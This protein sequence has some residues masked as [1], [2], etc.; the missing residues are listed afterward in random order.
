M[1]TSLRGR[2]ALVASALLLVFLAMS[3][4]AQ[5]LVRS[6]RADSD[7]L[8]SQY[9]GIHKH[10]ED[11]KDGLRR[12]ESSLYPFVMHGA[13]EG[14]QT[15]RQDLRALV[16]LRELLRSDALINGPDLRELAAALDHSLV[17]LDREVKTLLA[18]D[19]GPDWRE[20]RVRGQIG[21][22]VRSAYKFVHLVERRIYDAV[23]TSTF[24]SLGTSDIVSR[25]SRAGALM[26]AVLLL[27]GYAAFELS[28]RRPLLKVAQA[29]DAEGRGESLPP[30][31]PEARTRE[32]ALLTAAFNGMRRQVR[33]RQLRLESVLNNTSDG[34]I[35]IDSRRRIQAFNA[36]AAA[37]FGYQEGDVTGEDLWQ[38]LSGDTAQLIHDDGINDTALQREIYLLG[39]R[40]D[41]TV[42]DLSCKVSEFTIDGRR[43]FNAMVADVS[44]RKAMF[45]RLTYLAEHD[46]LT[47]LY[48]RRYF[49]EELHRVTER[50]KR[51]SGSPAALLVVDLDHFKLVNDTLGHQA[52]DQLLVEIARKLKERGRE[53]DLMARLGGDEFAVLVFDVDEAAAGQVATSY[54][55]RLADYSFKFMGRAVEIGC[56][57]GVAMLTTEVTKQDVL[58]RADLA[59]RIAKQ[60]G[61]NRCHFYQPEDEQSTARLSAEIGYARLINHA[62]AEGRLALVFQPIV[63]L[64]DGHP[65]LHEVLVRLRN[66]DGSLLPAYSFITEAERLGLAPDI[67]AWVVENALAAI[68]EGQVPA[69]ARRFSIN[70]SGLSIGH[71][72]V[73]AVIREGLDRYG[74]DPHR[75]VFE[76]TETAAVTSLTEAQAFIHWLRGLGCE[77][78]LDDFGSGYASFLYL[79]ELPTDYVKLDG[80][81][82]RNIDSD[83]LSLAVVKAMNDVAQTLGRKT[84]AE[85]VEN[86]VVARHL[87]EIGVDYGQGYFFG[88]PALAGLP[89]AADPQRQQ[90]LAPPRLAPAAG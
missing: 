34:I 77:T 73:A 53:G 65:V 30:A 54:C 21:P 27:A 1:W 90:P 16:G 82:I 59:C 7:D 36:A 41:G 60:Q 66:D 3:L 51:G 69:G 72:R 76:L 40:R 12:L 52:G 50:A 28:I 57:I 85:F 44:E 67:D 78:A 64:A 87:K 56:S 35:T 32:L 55:R 70:L 71:P 4:Y 89:P 43:L 68:A 5:D 39:R 9:Y 25:L 8:V 19:G 58:P 15:L 81:L 10:L 11:A 20:K 49:M 26:V 23:L 88:R 22:A 29:L 38:L 46:P 75:I 17:K 45:D 31:L 18:V 74:V 14:S 61:R 24:Q 13:A 42:F 63:D 47:G 2:F 80:A 6:R 79:R 83:R 37:L 84:V 48:N 33:S 86:E 62:L